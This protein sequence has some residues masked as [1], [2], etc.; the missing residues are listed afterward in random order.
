M[1]VLIV[2]D[3]APIAQSLVR[4][5]QG[6]RPGTEIVGITTD[7]PGSRSMIAAHPDLDLILSDI[8]I[9]DGLSFSVFDKLQ[10][11]AMVVFTTAYD[12]Y[13]LKAFD[14]NCI[15][16]LMKPVSRE[17]LERALSRCERHLPRADTGAIRSVSDQITRK[18]ADFRRRFFLQRGQD[19]MI[20]DVSEIGYIYSEKGA[21]RVFLTDGKWGDL[22]CSLLEFAQGLQS[23]RF[24][25]I[26]RQAI[27][28]IDFVGSISPGPGR[29]STV[30]LN[31]PFPGKS[32]VITQ[33]RKKELL[34]VLKGKG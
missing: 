17:A 33:E 32:F 16:Y 10:T 28:N 18:T 13:A 9:D 3:E 34:G 15:D 4:M 30:T 24:V 14:Y 22:D 2:E 19:T 1:K 20:C 27:V 12:E 6:L 21:T 7:I 26:S 8:K 11:E 23:D 5:V 29:D 31:K 25:R